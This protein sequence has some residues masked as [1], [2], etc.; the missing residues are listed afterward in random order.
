MRE[1]PMCSNADRAAGAPKT[2]SPRPLNESAIQT[3]RIEI[4]RHWHNFPAAVFGLWATIDAQADLNYPLDRLDHQ[5]RT[6]FP[7]TLEHHQCEQLNDPLS[8]LI[9]WPVLR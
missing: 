5:P 2:R 7:I 9:S 8:R 3:R 6:S 1:A 4:W